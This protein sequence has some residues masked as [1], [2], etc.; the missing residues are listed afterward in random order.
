[1]AGSPTEFAARWITCRWG[2]G[3][4]RPEVL[5]LA[6]KPIQATPLARGFMVAACR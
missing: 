1:M 4:H 5:T 3:N 2:L 6:E